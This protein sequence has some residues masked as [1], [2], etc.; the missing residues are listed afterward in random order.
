MKKI[1]FLLITLIVAV[2]SFVLFNSRQVFNF[3]YDS[4]YYENLYYHS[5]WNIPQSTRGISDGDLY[6]FVGY[7]L[8][9]GENPFY[10]NF[11]VPPLA[12]Y[13]YGLV[14]VFVGNPYFLNIFYYLIIIAVFYKLSDNLFK[15]NKLNLLSTLLLVV[16]PFIATQI[17]E[18]MLDLPLTFFFLI[19]FW[20]FI[21]YLSVKDNKELILAGLF[22]GLAT[23]VKIGVYTPLIGLSGFFV[24]YLT[25]K[26]IKSIKPYLYT[27]SVAAGYV[28]SYISYFIR[29]PNPIPWIKL[30]Q[31]PIEFYMNSQFAVD[32]L[33]QWKGIFLNTYQ[34]W[35]GSGKTSF[36][37]WSLLLPIGVI[38]AF[39][40]LFWSLKKK[41]YKWL[42][43][44]LSTISVLFVN[45]LIA[46]WPRYLM[47]IIPLL[48]L[49][50]IKQLRKWTIVIWFIIISSFLIT[51][52]TLTD[53]PINGHVEAVERFFSTRAYRE[54]YRSLSYEQREQISEEV[55]INTNENFYS[56]FDTRKIELKLLNLEVEKNNAQANYEITLDTKFGELKRNQIIE[57]IYKDNQWRLNW[58]WEYIY[59]NYSPE[60][61][62][63]ISSEMF[64]I[65]AVTQSQKTVLVS[66]LRPAVYAIPRLMSDWNKHNDMIAKITMQKPSESEKI[67]RSVVPDKYPIFIGLL[68][69]R[70]ANYKELIKD[71]P[72]IQIKEIYSLVPFNNKIDLENYVS[73]IN[74]IL[75]EN[76][77]QFISTADIKFINNDSEIT[78]I[79]TNNEVPITINY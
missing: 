2:I 4:E 76:P 72:S 79:D 14:E 32:H 65:K 44:S 56:T 64:K 36:G 26:R 46:F 75:K 8:V 57:Y 62:I 43:L 22:L 61:N 70:I 29:H 25:E 73:T 78:I 24:I 19:H 17:K 35:W 37:D 54:L 59:P 16:T 55:F 28:I 21:K 47:P 12:K 60:T 69:P 48:V 15:N 5:Q 51:S 49:F 3:T 66:G 58:K 50:T 23:G 6:K 18:T 63:V 74:R 39:Y 71:I 77:S 31:K 42:Y 52:K 53:H 33:N 20:Y 7:R 1:H 10:L 41:D 34:G 40:I 11:E 45:S 30:H 13:L 68:D 67:I 27:V 38:F 9:Y